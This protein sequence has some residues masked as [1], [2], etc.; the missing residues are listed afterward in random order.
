V[1]LAA[2]YLAAALL[3]V[4]AVSS[5][6]RRIPPRVETGQPAPAGAAR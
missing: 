3:L 5:W 2:F 6:R 4:R 1:W